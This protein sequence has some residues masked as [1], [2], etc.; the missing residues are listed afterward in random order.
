MPLRPLSAA[1]TKTNRPKAT[2]SIANKTR[3]RRES[4]VTWLVESV[5]HFADI[6]IV[7]GL[8]VA[9]VFTPPC[10]SQNR[11]GLL[12][13]PRR[14]PRKHTSQHGMRAQMRS[15]AF[16]SKE[17]GGNIIVKEEKKKV[18]KPTGPYCCR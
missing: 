9:I 17:Q 18:K 2:A 11:F 6:H 12:T 16:Q 5:P 1:A 15:Q 4:R 13:T 3:S 14:S 10:T 8:V 7:L